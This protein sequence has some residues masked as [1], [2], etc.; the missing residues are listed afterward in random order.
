MLIRLREKMRHKRIIVWGYKNPTHTHSYI[1]YGFAIGAQALGVETHWI[2]HRDNYDPALFD[3]ALVITEQ[4]GPLYVAPGM[5]LSK[6]S[7]YFVHYLGNRPDNRENPDGASLYR[8]RVGR[9]L[10]FRY[11]GDGWDDKNYKYKIDKEKAIKISEGSRFEKGTNGYDIFYS[12]F[13]T[14]I[15]PHQFNFDDVYLPKERKSFFAGTIRD[16]NEYLFPPF[17]KALEENNIQFI[18]NCPTRNPL[19]TDVIRKEI[20]SS[21]FTA[22]LR[23]KVWQEGGYIACRLLKNI[24]YGVLGATNSVAAKNM[25]G[26]MIVYHENPYQLVYDGLKNVENYDM[27][28]R[29]MKYVQQNHTYVN[30]IQDIIKV[31]DE[32]V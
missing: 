27:I 10:D 31:S 8:G 26:D 20:T 28:K 25:F 16:D 32:Y 7:T 5:P 17:I 23:G 6:T 14:D 22:D 18:H 1:H 24:S 11:N 19:P 21:I 30:R 12:Y 4:Y 3:D 13:A 9:F 2:D 15:L 29:S